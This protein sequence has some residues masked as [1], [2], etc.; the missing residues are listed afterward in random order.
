MQVYLCLEQTLFGDASVL[1]YLMADLKQILSSLDSR[2]YL[3]RAARS[4]V[5]VGKIYLS[6]Y[7]LGMGASGPTFYDDVV[8]EF[9]SPHAK[10]KGSTIAV[11]VGASA[12]GARKGA[13]SSPNGV[14]N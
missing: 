9:F 2:G 5:G 3:G 13:D 8:T 1:F 6:S 12:Y 4:G 11:G 7:S 10:E 14:A